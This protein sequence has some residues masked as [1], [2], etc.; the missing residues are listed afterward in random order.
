MLF[1][2]IGTLG[3][4]LTTSTMLEMSQDPSS[5]CGVDTHI[6]IQLARVR[7]PFI[8]FNGSYMTRSSLITYSCAC[9]TKP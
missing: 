8:P 5:C 6:I 1:I 7:S 4:L 9:P 3:T 2:S